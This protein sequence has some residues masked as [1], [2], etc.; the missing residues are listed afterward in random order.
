MGVRKRGD[1]GRWLVSLDGPLR[2][3]GSA[4]FVVTDGVGLDFSVKTERGLGNLLGR[5]WGDQRMPSQPFLSMVQPLN[6]GQ[7]SEPPDR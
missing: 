1:I 2:A 6:L 5:N 4:S 7:N 3:N